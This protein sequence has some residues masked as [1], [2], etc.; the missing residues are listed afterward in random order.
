MQPWWERWPGRLEW[1]LAELQEVGIEHRMDQNAFRKGIVVLNIHH[2]I[3]DRKED[4]I[5]RFPDV[6]P[7]MRFEIYAP[8]LKLDHHQNPFKKNLCMI[9]R[10]TANWS[11]DDTVAQYITSRLPKV[12]QTG[13]RA[14]PFSAKQLEE[15]QG[16]PISDYYPYAPDSVVLIDSSWSID[17]SV[18]GGIIKLGSFGPN[19]GSLHFAILAVMDNNK[20]TLVQTEPEISEL[21]PYHIRGIWVRSQQPILEDRPEHFFQHLASIDPKLGNKK[22]LMLSKRHVIGVLFPEEVAWRQNDDGWLFF[23]LQQMGR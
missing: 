9:G 23:V 10:S 11:I 17:P 19:P 4:F 5:V 15:I 20:N 22:W 18:G 16:E 6:Y 8:G 13:E 3:K 1:E 12:L 21:Y 2:E 7:Y 14:D